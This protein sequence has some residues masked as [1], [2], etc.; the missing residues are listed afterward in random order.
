MRLFQFEAQLPPE[1]IEKLQQFKQERKPGY[2]ELKRK[3]QQVEELAGMAKKI[4]DMRAR[5]EQ[6]YGDLPP[7]IQ[8][9][10]ELADLYPV[11]ETDQ[12]YQDL[13][14]R[15]V[16]DLALLQN[17]VQGRRSLY[18]RESVNYNGAFW[19]SQVQGSDS[20]VSPVGAVPKG[21]RINTKKAPNVTKKLN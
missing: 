12:D 20:P 11:S 9:D 18:K 8:A 17:Y 1:A 5:A 3:L 19:L 13:K 7:G 14:Q 16:K 6:V 2:L 4:E 15:F 10:L 21:Q